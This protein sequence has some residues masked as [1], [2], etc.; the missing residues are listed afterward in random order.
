MP[1]RR[2]PRKY[3]PDADIPLPIRVAM[4]APVEQVDQAIEALQ[5]LLAELNRLRFILSRRRE[6]DRKRFIESQEKGD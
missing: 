1:H 3:K 6:K 5:K 2:L 4:D